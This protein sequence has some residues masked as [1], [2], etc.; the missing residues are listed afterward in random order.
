MNTKTI[1]RYSRWLYNRIPLI[2]GWLRR[3]AVDALAQDASPESVQALAQAVT[4]SDD[5]QVRNSALN[6]LRQL[7]GW[8]QIGAVCGVWLNTR[9]PDLLA[10][11][12][13][14]ETV[15]VV[16]EV[17]THSGDGQAR[18]AALQSLRQLS[19][20]GSINA[21][22]E[23]WAETRNENLADL[24][25]E[26]EWMASAPP[27][28]K[29]L[30][31]LKI[32]RLDVIDDGKTKTVE[33]LVAACRDADP[34]IAERALYVLGNLK[35]EKA[36]Q[37]LCHL[38]IEGT[39]SI[40]RDVALAAGYI[41]RDEQQRASYF[42]L[43]KQWERYDML[44]FDRQFLRAA[45]DEADNHL[46]QRIREKLRASGR[47]D[48]LPILTEKGYRAGVSGMSPGE[49]DLFLQ[50]LIVNHEWAKLWDLVFEV[51]F[52]WS[53]RI[54][55]ALADSEWRPQDRDEPVFEEL[56]SF[57][58]RGLPVHEDQIEQLFSSAL[59]QAQVGL[60]KS[61]LFPPAV[62]RA[63]A[64]VPGRINSVAFSPTRP[65]I[66]VGTG[67]RK[68]VLWNYQRAER[69]RVLGGFKRSIGPVTFTGDG[70]LLCAERTNTRDGICTI[71]AWNDPWKNER[72]LI[73]G[74]HTG[75]V[76]A[77]EPVGT[78]QAISTGRDGEI[79][80][81]DVPGRREVA[82]QRYAR[83]DDG[84][85]RTMCVSPDEKWV[86][87]V[88]AG[89]KMMTL[90]QLQSPSSWWG[91]SRARYV[92]FPPDYETLIVG[93]SDGDVTTY[94]PVRYATNSEWLTRHGQTLTHHK[95][96]MKGVEMLRD[97]SI[98]VSASSDGN[99]HFTAWGNRASVG[100]VQ[101]P[102]GNLT[103]LHISPDESFMAVGSSEAVLS[104]WDLR[105]LAMPSI[106]LQPFARSTVLLLPMLD[107]LIDNERLPQQARLALEFAAC[108]L[109][110]RFQFDIEV[111]DAPTIMMGE[112]DIEI[113]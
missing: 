12:T 24:L 41:P 107:A 30:T 68:V 86:A 78:S 96:R 74:K 94:K 69:E 93:R 101:A 11:L 62:L 6:A 109:R 108:V 17:V 104:L 32:E 106:L 2:G 14:R 35:T 8:Q 54:V 39:D 92:A 45:Y 46:R 64:Q 67:R 80:L 51:Q 52:S 27:E 70:A 77:L 23:V 91:A 47:T 87:A 16:V 76:T 36:Q 31:A 105:G 5:R 110:H 57:I 18:D 34:I 85:A 1:A 99:I 38:V 83:Y 15:P 82:R 19:D 75:S 59:R 103:S 56:V 20:R 22:C 97:F 88:G 111:E 95:G 49:L 28:I 53:A 25:A 71:Y 26:R 89:V 21:V 72:P 4:R 9:H 61:Q 13:R 84:W 90:P 10:L 98:V 40:A 44:D 3:T 55:G 73:L 60:S 102:D 113:D 29:V 65:V 42:F 81:W 112:F 37:A 66:A 50:T 43:T 100:S 7:S 79:V 63:T 33:L 48:F 58:R